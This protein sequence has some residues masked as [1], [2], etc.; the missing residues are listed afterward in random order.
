MNIIVFDPSGSHGTFANTQSIVF[1]KDNIHWF[2]HKNTYER[3]CN[4]GKLNSDSQNVHYYSPGK[5]KLLYYIKAIILIKRI[6]SDVI[7]FN[8][9]QSDWSLNFLFL[10]FVKRSKNIIVTI[11]NLNS[12]FAPS[13]KGLRAMI[14][15]KALKLA[16]KKCLFNVYS[17]EI[18]K[19]ILHRLPAARVA[20]V[21][22]QV[23][24]PLTSKYGSVNKKFSIIIPGSVDL[25]RR[26]YSIILE[27]A[28]YLHQTPRL[29]FI[30]LGAPAD[31]NAKKLLNQLEL[32]D[33]VVCFRNFVNDNL[34]DQYMESA[35]IIL[36]PLNAAFKTNDS[37]EEYGVT[38]ETGISFAS[39]R[40]A[41]PLI[42]PAHIKVMDELKSGAVFYKTPQQL[43][44]IITHLSSN[45]EAYSVLK[46][47]AEINA[48]KF[49][50]EEIRRQFMNWLNE[51]NLT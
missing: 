13:T 16:R 43:I 34:Y 17:S 51:N 33:K 22:Y 38:K 37:I 7:F 23:H 4:Q 19:Q 21:P 40:Y 45:N 5:L 9:L 30:L 32:K 20:L 27:I 41:L 49:E 36:G 2:I 8:T 3:L 48:K 1:E 26:D 6:E 28:Q 11:H 46:A 29:E 18:K 14:K 47:N 50:P 44:E 25:K 12:F 35:H 39:I 31:E 10:V 24:V 42:L 15:E